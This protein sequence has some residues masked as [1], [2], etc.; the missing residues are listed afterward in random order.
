M[1]TLPVMHYRGSG[2]ITKFSPRICIDLTGVP[3]RG[4]G[5]C[6]PHTLLASA[7]PAVRHLIHTMVYRNTASAIP[8]I[9]YPTATLCLARRCG[10]RQIQY[11]RVI[12]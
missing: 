7:M 11:L 6:G 10:M 9:C 3:N 4:Y 2:V 12:V 8:T 1:V 5:G